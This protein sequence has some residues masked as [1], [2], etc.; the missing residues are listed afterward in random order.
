VSGAKAHIGSGGQP[1]GGHWW[2]LATGTGGGHTLWIPPDQ[3]H[4]VT[5]SQRRGC[6]VIMQHKF[7]L[8]D[9]VFVEEACNHLHSP[10]GLSFRGLAFTYTQHKVGAIGFRLWLW[11]W[12]CMH[13]MRGRM[14][15]RGGLSTRSGGEVR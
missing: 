3:V 7:Q 8:T 15:G 9:Q 5:C 11:L 2:R 12:L 14:T 1:N 10:A 6:P 4:V 13:H